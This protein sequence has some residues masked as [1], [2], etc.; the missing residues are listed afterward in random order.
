MNWWLLLIPVISACIGWFANLVVFK[1]LFH[2][3]KPVNIL[4]LTIQGV[5]PKRHAHLA[6]QLGKLV[7]SEL[8]SF[9]DIEQKI[10]SADN[11]QKIKPEVEKHVDKFLREKL[12]EAFP[13]IGAFIGDKTIDQLK[14]LFLNELEELF[15]VIMQGYMKNL[16]QELDLEQLV[17]AKVAS[18]SADRLEM[19][20]N[21]NLVKELRLAKITGAVLGFLIGIIQMLIAITILK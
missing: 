14:V 6:Q 15:P 9:R 18:I 12:K 4:G 5:F 11:F 21:D 10:I 17:T 8:L 2:P 19:A 20:L 16:Q 13:Y 1:M 3:K 7:S